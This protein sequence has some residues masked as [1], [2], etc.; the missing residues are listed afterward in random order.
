M[1]DAPSNVSVRFGTDESNVVFDLSY[2]VL[3]E[4]LYGK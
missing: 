4:Y 1:A 2:V 3:A